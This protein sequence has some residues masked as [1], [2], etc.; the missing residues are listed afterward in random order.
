MESGDGRAMGAQQNA[1]VISARR[2]DKQYG[3]GEATVRVLKSIDI[4]IRAGEM[5]AIMGPSG[6]GKSTLLGILSGLDTPTAGEVVLNGRDI[7]SLKE[8]ALA[9]VRNQSVGF[10]FQTFN[11]I[12][13]LTAQENVELPVQLNPRSKLN[14]ARRAKELLNQVGLAERAGHRPSQL[15]GGEQQ[16][17]AIARALANQ[18]PIIFADE[19]TGN[20]DS[21]N[22][23]AVMAMLRDLNAQL[24]VTIVIVTH[25]PRVAAQCHR[26]IHLLDGEVEHVQAAR[27][28]R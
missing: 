1:P 16:R 11:L 23:E 9:T 17:V 2:I 15:S 10:I 22:G 19:P 18:P 5:V 8:A 26:I 14:P 6:S 13:P 27:G 20:L 7:T 4:S 12:A 28:C 21:V 25:D 3:A 24:G